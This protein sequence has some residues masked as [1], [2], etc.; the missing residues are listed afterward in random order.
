MQLQEE[1]EVD[2]QVKNHHR[3]ATRVLDI[4][5]SKK[6]RDRKLGNWAI[7]R[8][9]WESRY[10]ICARIKQRMWLWW[11]TYL[12]VETQGLKDEEEFVNFLW[13]DRF[14]EFF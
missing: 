11:V 13:L 12:Q 6:V 5:S 9:G 14:V 1:A 7:G 2:T 4:P 8:E 3:I 10:G